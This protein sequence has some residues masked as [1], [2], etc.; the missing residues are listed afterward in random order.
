MLR[1]YITAF[2]ALDQSTTEAPQP[3]LELLYAERAAYIDPAVTRQGLQTP[4]LFFVDSAP[5]FNAALSETGD[6]ATRE[7][8]NMFWEVSKFLCE[9]AG[10]PLP[11]TMWVRDTS[12]DA[13]E[14]DEW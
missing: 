14:D 10:V 7:A 8:T 1:P 12:G 4:G 13:A 3:L 6:A 11:G 9:D 5:P 2:L